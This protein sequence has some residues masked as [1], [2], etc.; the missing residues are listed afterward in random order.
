MDLYDLYS[1]QCHTNKIKINLMRTK[2]KRL[3]GGWFLQDFDGVFIN[4]IQI[5]AFDI[6]TRYIFVKPSN[7]TYFK[8]WTNI[9]IESK[10]TL[11][12]F[13]KYYSIIKITH[14]RPFADNLWE[15]FV[16]LINWFGLFKHWPTFFVK[17]ALCQYKC[18]WPRSITRVLLF[19]PILLIYS[20]K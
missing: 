12:K 18:Y 13:K 1:K 10:K 7:K 3:F 16:S 8:I 6:Y 20:S 14:E 2:N 15:S 11:L 19:F 9:F 4:T 5:E 17:S